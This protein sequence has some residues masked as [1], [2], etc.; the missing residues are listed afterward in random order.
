M[1]VLL[2]V[3]STRIF[4][5]YTRP[6]GYLAV[7]L[8]V[9]F[10]L[11]LH[12]VWIEFGRYGM[13]V[14][15]PYPSVSPNPIFG[16]NLLLLRRLVLGTPLLI[17]LLGF[18]L[19]FHRV[20]RTGRAFVISSWG[21]AT[22]MLLSYHYVWIFAGRLG[23]AFPAPIPGHHYLFHLTALISVGFGLAVSEVVRRSVSRI[24]ALEPIAARG[25]AVAAITL[26]VVGL[27]WP[28]W[29]RRADFTEI[30]FM[31]DEFKRTIP[32]GLVSWI[33]D[34]A[35]PD[36]VF[37]CTD[38][39]SLYVVSPAGR[40]VVATN[41]YFSSPFVDWHERDRDRDAMYAA[42]KR[43]DLV[44]FDRLARRYEVRYVIASEE[45]DEFLRSVSG[46]PHRAD[47]KLS[48]SS[49]EALPGF[50][51]LFESQGRT[52]FRRRPDLRVES[53]R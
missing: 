47:P 23:H 44:T 37:L 4:S 14:L 26:L 39:L 29:S 32:G 25:L 52:V 33:R 15:N 24:P 51:K 38:D 35:D 48:P 49:L 7:T 30:R 8:G 20:R 16:S 11:S 45:I 27:A 53:K 46:V 36:D 6:F 42:L 50:E 19:Y 3:R 2:A 10:L 9:A 22:L 31:A 5:S 40:K 18:A 17:A 28:S 13:L 21:V 41:K 43:G 12:M 1:L 34:Q